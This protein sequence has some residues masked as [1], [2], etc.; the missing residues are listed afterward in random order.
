MRP[1]E[2]DDQVASILATDWFKKSVTKEAVKAIVD[3]CHQYADLGQ[4]HVIIDR[5]G[6]HEWVTTGYVERKAIY[7]DIPQGSES[8][9]YFADA[10]LEAITEDQRPGEE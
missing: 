2:P 9:A 1:P 4:G 7:V 3:Y 8:W 5:S 10:L 6:V